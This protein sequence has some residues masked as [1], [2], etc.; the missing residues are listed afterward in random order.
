MKKTKE[1]LI[2]DNKYIQNQNTNRIKDEVLKKEK[3]Y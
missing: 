3:E 1:N 2:R